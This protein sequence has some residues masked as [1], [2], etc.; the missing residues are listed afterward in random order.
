MKTYEEMGYTTDCWG[1]NQTLNTMA[2]L[3]W[4]LTKRT[5][6]KGRVGKLTDS[7]RHLFGFGGVLAVSKGGNMTQE[8][9]QRV[10]VFLE[11][12][13]DHFDIPLIAI[14]RIMDDAM[15]QHAF[16]MDSHRD[17]RKELLE[18]LANVVLAAHKEEGQGQLDLFEDA[19]MLAEKAKRMLDS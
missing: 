14:K 7:L 18:D 2:K 10:L 11:G 12:Y 5:Q 1:G 19:R 6:E 4:T 8:L 13:A 15:G 3:V 17:R 9:K 16:L